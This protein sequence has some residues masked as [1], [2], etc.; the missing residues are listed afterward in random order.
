ML[1]SLDFKDISPEDHLGLAGE[2]E[3]GNMNRLE[4]EARLG[5]QHNASTYQGSHADWVKENIVSN[6]QP[7]SQKRC[8]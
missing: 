5:S 2:V 3:N 8:S 6:Q 1:T 4:G 7:I